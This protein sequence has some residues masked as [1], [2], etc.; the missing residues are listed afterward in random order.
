MKLRLLLPALVALCAHSSFAQTVDLQQ[1]WQAGKKYFQTIETQQSSV[2][3]IGPQKME[4]ATHMTMEVSF[5]VRPK[6]DGKTRSM[7]VTYERVAMDM[8][9]NGQ[10]MGFDSANPSANADPMGLGKS[11]GSTVG[12]ELIVSLDEK[13][14]VT[15]IDNYDAYI[16]QLGKSPVPGMD[17][18]EMHS[19]EALI[20]MINQG[21]LNALPGKPVAPGAT[22]PY[23]QDLALPKIGKVTI[24]GTYGFKGMA[25]H[26]GANCAE[27]ETNGKL[28]MDVSAAS[29]EGAPMAMKVTDGKIKGTM[30]FDPQ[31]GVVRESQN[32]QEMTMSMKNPVDPTA[33]DL[34]IP[35]R[36]TVT[37]KTTKIEDLK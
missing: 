7:T 23:R 34:N 26:D 36:Q 17:P 29:P 2:I 33:A 32:Q 13:G 8:N 37:L 25:A 3:E 18:K 14:E 20:Q 35:M 22:W 10:K 9:V 11:I 4:Q 16:E 1:R 28:T 21:A 24:Q 12:K 30:W 5:A 31:L 19:R 6:T 27:I 15:G